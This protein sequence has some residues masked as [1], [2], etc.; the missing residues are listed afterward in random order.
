ML[1]K[2]MYITLLPAPLIIKNF[3]KNEPYCNYE[4]YLVELLNESNY[5]QTFYPGKFSKT[6]VESHGECDAINS[7]YQ[8]DFKLLASSTALQKKSVKSPRLARDTNG[9]IVSGKNTKDKGK[10]IKSSFI[11]LNFRNLTLED[12]FEIYNGSPK[13]HSVEYEISN[14]LDNLAKQKHLLL[15]FPYIFTFKTPHTEEESINSIIQGINNDFK[16]A[17]RFRKKVAK[18]YDTFWV[19]ILN[20]EF[21]L[22]KIKNNSVIFCEKIKTS[23]IM[24]FTYLKDTYTEW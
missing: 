23:K 10:I 12:L 3:V 13:S 18:N 22:F 5:F 14:V 21:L 6:L 17:F 9:C 1:D 15:F 16:E 2:N 4:L 24:K 19:S 20:D 11:N 8:I 7:H